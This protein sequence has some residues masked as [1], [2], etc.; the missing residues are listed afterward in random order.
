MFL[1][2]GV[3]AGVLFK[4]SAVERTSAFQDYI[5]TRVQSAVLPATSSTKE[6]LFDCDWSGVTKTKAQHVAH[7][8]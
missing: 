6:K 7:S 4:T 5:R 1:L 8:L 2:S 3:Y